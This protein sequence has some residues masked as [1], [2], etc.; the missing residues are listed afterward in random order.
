MREL[1]VTAAA[2]DRGGVAALIE[3]AGAKSWSEVAAASRAAAEAPLEVEGLIDLGSGVSALVVRIEPG[4]EAVFLILAALELGVPLVLVPATWSSAQLAAAVGRELA[5]RSVV[6]AEQPGSREPEAIATLVATSGTTTGPRFACLSRRALV[7]AADAGAERVGWGP[8]GRWWAALTPTTI[9][10]LSI[11][12]RALVSR[13]AVAV[14]RLERF[15]PEAFTQA[16][17]T[18]G[19]THTS[20]VPTMVSRLVRH[21]QQAPGTL[22]AMLVGGAAASTD[23]L[24]EAWN[25]GWPALPSWG[26]TE[27]AAQAATL[28]LAWLRQPD[29]APVPLVRAGCGPALPG[30]HLEISQPDSDGVGALVVAGPTLFSGYLGNQLG[31]RLWA[32]GD[33][34]RLDAAGNLHVVG[35]RD[36]VVIS[37]GRKTHPEQIEAA[38]AGFP[39]VEAACVV[40]V[41]DP[42]WG[43]RLVAVLE[44]PDPADLD[45][46]ALRTW[47][48]SRLQRW[49]I[50]REVRVV[51]ALPR[52]SGG[53][54]DR[55]R[56]LAELA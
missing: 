46:E 21:R 41:P 32:S 13:A 30:V 9:G 56:L 42:E 37:G 18:T 5:P 47:L 16:L 54:I 24:V 1:S 3:A 25:L 51:A 29:S 8:G 6:L 49:E 15:D 4:A 38:I 28:P 23:L 34:A 43:Q 31:A 19:A 48:G 33:L 26:A 14:G 20:V 17:A 35:R 22:R 36:G 50:P 55:R 12:T 52:L 11:L 39:G 10:G 7:A 45:V 27:T 53:K 44:A 40:G 2:E